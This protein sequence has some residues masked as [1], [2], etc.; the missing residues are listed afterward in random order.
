MERGGKQNIF[1]KSINNN[2]FIKSINNNIFIK[3]INNNIFIKTYKNMSELYTDCVLDTISWILLKLKSGIDPI[4][5][6]EDEKSI[7]FHIY[8]EGWEMTIN[9]Y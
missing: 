9:N 7:M 8:G 6:K 1:I 5:L 4:D 2:I 3:T